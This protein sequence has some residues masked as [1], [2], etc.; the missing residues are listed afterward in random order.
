ME[1]DGQNFVKEPP[2]EQPRVKVK[3][4]VVERA[5]KSF[6]VK[7]VSKLH[8]KLTSTI[9]NAFA[10]T[11][12]QTCLTGPEILQLL[13]CPESYL[14]PMSHCIHGRTDTH[15]DIIGILVNI[16]Y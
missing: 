3:V 15:L 4:S 8:H 11:R 10:D 12:A 5:H 14:V 6:D 7:L 9:I 13:K 16:A 1:W 2:A